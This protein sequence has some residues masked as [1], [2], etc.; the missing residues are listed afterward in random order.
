VPGKAY[1][2]GTIFLQVVPVFRDVMD[3]TER[4]AKKQ[5]KALGDEME[6]GGRD[7]GKRTSKAMNEELVKGAS[8]AGD[9]AG[10]D[11][12]GRFQ[13]QM[14]QAAKSAQREMDKINLDGASERALADLDRVQRKL[15]V[16]TAEDYNIGVDTKKA[17]HDIEHLRAAVARLAKGDHGLTMDSNLQTV[18][19]DLELVSREAEKV[20]AKKREIRFDA[21]FKPL[22]RQIGSFEAKMRAS[23]KSAAASLGDNLDPAIKKIKAELASIS[24]ADFG[25]D[26]STDQARERIAAL[27]AEIKAFAK[28]ETI[29]FDVRADTMDAYTNLLAVNALGTELDG[30]H[31]DVSVGLDA[32]EAERAMGA[33]ERKVRDGAKS[34]ERNLDGINPAIVRIKSALA[35]IGNPSITPDLNSEH[36]IAEMR[37]LAGELD[38]LAGDTHLDV[39]VRTNA[40]AALTELIPLLTAFSAID[41][42]KLNVSVDLDAGKAA[43]EAGILKTVM[44]QVAG[45]ADG[46]AN[47]FRSFNGIILAAAA[48]IPALVPVI[49][50]LGGGLLALIPILGAVGAGF[51]VMLAGFSGIG[52]IIKGFSDVHKNAANDAAV[53]AKRINSAAKSMGDAERGLAR[54]RTSAAQANG[55]A[56]RSTARAQEQAAEQIKN[57]IASQVEAEH[58]LANAQRDARDAQDKLRLARKQAQKELEDSANKRAQNALDVRQGVVDVFNATVSNNAVQQDGSSTNLD[59]ETSSIALEQARLRLKEARDEQK[60]LATEKKQQDKDGINGTAVVKTAQ[61]QLTAALERQHDA[62]IA[63]GKAAEAVNKARRDGA[64]SVADAVRNQNRTEVAGAQSVADAQRAL[65]ASQTSYAE[66]VDQSSASVRN[67]KDALSKVG[68]AGEKFARFIYGLKDEAYGLRDSIQAAML[69]GVQRGL[70]Y[71]INTYGPQ[72]QSFTTRM[73]GAI[74]KMFDE[75]GHGLGRKAFRE[76][77]YTYGLLAPKLMRT[78]GKT[79]GNWMAIFARIMTIIAPYAERLNVAL[80]HISEHALKFTE[81]SKGTKF[82]TDFMDYASRVGPLVADFFWN[83]WGAIVA[84]A[85]AM[86]PWGETV[87]KGLDALAR[88]IK[89]MDPKVLSFIVTSIIG[90]IIAMQVAV[91]AVALVLAGGAIVGSTFALVLFAV[92]AVG[93]AI[94][95]AY[96]NFKGF[97]DFVD[98]YVVPILKLLWVWFKFVIWGTILLWTS[99]WKAVVFAAKIIAA[100]WNGFLWPVFKALAAVVTWLWQKVLGPIFKAIWVVFSFIGKVMWNTWKNVIYPILSLWFHVTLWLWKLAL[101]PVFAL[102][103]V[104]FKALGV[105]MSWVWKNAIKP[106]FDSFSEHVLPKLQSA[107]STVIDAIKKMWN[108]LK[109]ILA[110]P[111]RFVIEK[112]INGG[113]IK[114]FN[115]VADKVG[116]KPMKN[117]P[118]PKWTQA[119]GKA[120]GGSLRSAS[121]YNVYPGYTPGRDVGFIGISGGEGILRPEATRAVG[122]DWIAQINAAAIQGGV[123]GVKKRLGFAGGFKSG[124]VVKRPKTV[125]PVPGHETGTYPGH[126][127]VDINRG[128]GSQ[129]YGDPIV[130]F[131][132]GTITYVGYGRGY[133]QAIFEKGPGYPEVVYG[134]TSKTY[135]RAGQHVNA[136]T[137]IGRVGSTGNSSA[138]HLHFGP[139]HNGT[140]AAALALLAGANNLDLL[141]FGAGAINADG[142]S[143][144]SLP[145]WV[146]R[147]LKGPGDWVKKRLE[148]PVKALEKKFG[149]SP[150]IKAVEGVGMKLVGGVGDKIKD[151]VTGFKDKLSS[152]AASAGNFVS[153]IA[154]GALDAITGGN[155]VKSDVRA[156]AKAYGWDKGAEWDAISYIVSHESGWNPNAANPGSSARGLFQKMTSIHGPIEK[157]AAGQAKWGLNYIAGRY[158]DPLAAERF[159]KSH[160]NYADG[161][162]VPEGPVSGGT[163]DNGTMMYDNGGYLPPGLTTVLNLTGKPEPVFTDEQFR[164]GLA[165]GGSGVHYEPH[166]H[167][168]DLTARDVAFD[169]DLEFRRLGR[170]SRRYGGEG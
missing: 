48:L 136:G 166:F 168:S 70:E 69:P 145:G 31:W 20:A 42:R 138:P 45:S 137:L 58:N 4:Y 82:W 39:D 66:A 169:F 170:T 88:W 154:H 36:V 33:F 89:D 155:G 37:G 117:V 105:A 15:K 90:L 62:Q 99:L 79:T 148:A 110:A 43:A 153:G 133:G 50:A 44:N 143:G 14:K 80:L 100:V 47:S 108:G 152:A 109:D 87:L 3:E 85:K 98:K 162:V 32:K 121:D 95:A 106:I 46:G 38:A 149:D 52:P 68:P 74:G 103:H 118:V 35:D 113:I 6:A 21:N 115:W 77:F 150:I 7:A 91:G 73:G 86:A 60:A 125:W 49:G 159:W 63:V 126:D 131:R 120:R 5:S 102:I 129:D 83:L 18:L 123:E 22:E 81:S 158:G 24:D 71:I 130:A 147:I 67:L 65:A 34:S 141:Q 104:T 75:A 11:Y 93:V 161:G 55:D 76:F 128:S 163:P 146:G 54:A 140:T 64:R 25:I 17:E 13:A 40:K 16:M 116:S 122:H 26:I 101:K 59:K 10:S 144:V 19:K 156:V 56:A 114:A 53:S 61:D 157:T 78:A 23:A 127:G 112:V 28:D 72:F 165:G 167:K 135:V 160:G 124:G 92:I 9:K 1:S 119:K 2:A 134:H 139:A 57:A 97:H 41:G 27:S 142:S 8:D 164:N 132:N 84:I 51:G 94:Y 96:L 107:F 12:A 30:K 29:E 111:I 151:M